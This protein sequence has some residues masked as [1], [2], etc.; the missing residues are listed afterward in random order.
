VVVPAE[1]ESAQH[2]AHALGLEPHLGK[3]VHE[4]LHGVLVKRERVNKVLVV[5]A[6][7]Q[8]VA[9]ARLASGGL[10][11]TWGGGSGWCGWRVWTR[12]KWISRRMWICIYAALCV[13][14]HLRSGVL[15]SWACPT[16]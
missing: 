15:E 3:L 5:A 13:G 6:D 10:Q 2:G 1:P 7:A 9:A 14:T 16:T 4:V 8:L 12:S 11:V